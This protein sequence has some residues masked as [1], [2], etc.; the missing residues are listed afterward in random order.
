M[1]TRSLYRSS[2]IPVLALV[3]A[4]PQVGMARAAVNLVIEKAPKRQIAYTIFSG[5]STRR[6]SSCRSPTRRCSPTPRRCTSS[7]RRADIDEAAAR[8]E[9]MDYLARARVRADTGW[10]IRKRARRSTP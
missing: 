9:P 4:G 10:A 6:R 5:R 3:L 7:A 2:F 1:A 8:G